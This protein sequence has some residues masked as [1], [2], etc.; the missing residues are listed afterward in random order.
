M[1]AQEKHIYF[2]TKTYVESSQSMKDRNFEQTK[3]M[4]HL[5]DK[6]YTLMDKKYTLMDKNYT[7]MDKNYTLMDKKIYTFTLKVL[8][9]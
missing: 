1:P 9:I 8:L 4:L 2:S 6:N 5:M 7:L 3:Y